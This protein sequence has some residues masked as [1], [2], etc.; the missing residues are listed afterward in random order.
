LA[1]IYAPLS[2]LKWGALRLRGTFGGTLRL[3]AC[4]TPRCRN[5]DLMR[6]PPRVTGGD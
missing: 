2:H 4:K 3:P 1:R 5:N 6:R